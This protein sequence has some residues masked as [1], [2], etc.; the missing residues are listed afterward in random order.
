MWIYFLQPSYYD[1]TENSV[2]INVPIVWTG[3][4]KL[5]GQGFDPRSVQSVARY[6]TDYA[7]PAHRS[8]HYKN[9]IKCM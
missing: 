5:A 6:I 7:N 1:I 2:T 8:T 9:P 3:A 4:E